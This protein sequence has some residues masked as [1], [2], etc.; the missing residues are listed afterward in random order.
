MAFEFVQVWSC[1]QNSCN[2]FV[3]ILLTL[4]WKIPL[5]GVS[6]VDYEGVTGET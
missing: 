3:K 1:I 5:L 4:D 6:G 2:S